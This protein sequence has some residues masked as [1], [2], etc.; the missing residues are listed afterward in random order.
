MKMVDEKSGVHLNTEELNDTLELPEDDL[1]TPKLGSLSPRNSSVEQLQGYTKAQDRS[2][3]VELC[4]HEDIVI[5]ELHRNDHGIPS[6]S[7]HLR[8]NSRTKKQSS[9]IER[10]CWFPVT[11]IH[12][13]WKDSSCLRMY[14]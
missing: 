1:P 7:V 13:I 2:M 6:V 12:L 8:I 10:R 11:L 4:V 14:F 5:L 9:V 3:Y